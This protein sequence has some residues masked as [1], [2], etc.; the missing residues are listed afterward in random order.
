M[1]YLPDEFCPDQENQWD[2]LHGQD[3][4]QI[5]DC[6]A[7]IVNTGGTS[8][9]VITNKRWGADNW[10]WMMSMQFRINEPPNYGAE[11]GLTMFH[12]QDIDVNATLD[13]NFN[14]SECDYYLIGIKIGDHNAQG[15]ARLYAADVVD[16]VLSPKDLNKAPTFKYELGGYY[17]L[18]VTFTKTNNLPPLQITIK[19][20]NGSTL[21]KNAT[22]R[23]GGS[24]SNSN[25]ESYGILDSAKHVEILKMNVT[26]K[27][28]YISGT[29]QYG[30]TDPVIGDCMSSASPTKNVTVNAT[31]VATDILQ[32]KR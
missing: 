21:S 4:F 13:S 14:Y 2:T 31:Y 15:T 19:I 29:P 7:N 25:F 17:T 26:M 28:L 32:Y 5:N 1:C 20:H 10:P 22:L 12:F 6:E 16:G 11:V 30:F 9:N 24:K 27:S 18:N 23:V 3:I 8:H